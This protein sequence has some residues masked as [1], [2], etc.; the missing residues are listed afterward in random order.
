MKQGKMIGYLSQ[1]T[2]DYYQ[3]VFKTLHFVQN[4]AILQMKEKLQRLRLLLTFDDAKTTRRCLEL[5]ELWEENN[6]QKLPA[7]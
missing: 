4:G 1:S 7:F 2:I 3:S 6:K 5:M